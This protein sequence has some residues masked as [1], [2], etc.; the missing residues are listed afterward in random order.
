MPASSMTVGESHVCWYQSLP[1]WFLS[2]S[3]ILRLNLFNQL[4]CEGGSP[5]LSHAPI[6]ERRLLQVALRDVGLA[7]VGICDLAQLLQA[8]VPPGIVL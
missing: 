5:R 8:L 6:P 2:T 7:P 4:S 1:F 3:S